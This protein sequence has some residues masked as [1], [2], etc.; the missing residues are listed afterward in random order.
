MRHWWSLG[1]AADAGLADGGADVAEMAEMAEMEEE[2]EEEEDEVE[3]EEEEEDE[4]ATMGVEEL[5]VS[6]IRTSKRLLIK[7]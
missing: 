3:E 2:V 4:D 5:L 7:E 1:C 6:I